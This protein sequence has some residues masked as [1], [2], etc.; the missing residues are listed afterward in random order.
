DGFQAGLRLLKSQEAIIVLLNRTGMPKDVQM[1]TISLMPSKVVPG[2]DIVVV[3]VEKKASKRYIVPTGRVIVPAGRYIVLTGSVIVVTGRTGALIFLP[4]STAEEHL[5]VQKESKAKRISGDSP[6]SFSPTTYSVTSNFKTGSHKSSNVIED[7]LYSFVAYEDLE[8]VDKLDL[9]EMDLKWQMAMLSVRVHKFE[10]KVGR[11]IDFDR[12]ESARFNMQKVRCYKCQQRGHFARECR[13]KGGN[14]KQRYSSF[15]NKEIGRKEEDSKALVFVNTLVDWSNHD[16]EC[17]EVI[18]AKEFGMIAG[19]NSRKPIL[20]VMLEN[21]LSWVSPLRTKVGLGFTD[22]ISQNE[23]GWDDS[24]FSVFTTTSEDVEG[25]PTFHRFTKT[26]SIK[27]VPPPLT[28]DYTSLSDHSDLDESQMSYG[29]NSLTSNDPKSVTNDFVSCDDSDK[30]SEVKTSDF[31]SSD[32]SGKSSEHKPTDS[33]SCTS[34]SSVST[35]VNE[36]E[37]ES[38][39]R[40]PIKEPIIV[41]DLPSFICNSSDK[42]E[43]SSRTTCNKNGSFNKRA[44]HFRKHAS[45]VSKLYFICVSGTHLIKDCDFYEKQMTNTTVGIGV[46]TAVRPQPVLLYSNPENP[47]ELFQKLLEDL[48]ELPEYEKSQSRDR[49]IFLNDDEDHF[50]Q[51]K[52]C[53]ENSS[54]EIDASSSNQEKEEPPQDSNV[55][56]LIKEC[57]MEVFEEQKQIMENTM[58]ELVKICRHK[59][60]LCIHDNVE[61]LIESALNSKLLS[62]NSQRLDNKEQEVKNVVEQPIER[63]THIEKSLKKFRVIHKSFIS[64]NTSHISSI[65]AVVPIL[66][67]KEPEYSP[68]MGY[69]NSNTTLEMES[70]EIIKSG[71]EEL[72]PILSENEVTLEDKRE[73][74][75]PV[76]ENS[77]VCD[78][79][80]EIFFDSKDDDDIS[81]YDDFKDVEY[82][83]ASLFDPEIVNQEEEN[84]VHQE[85]DE[86]DLEDISQIQD[87]DLREKLLSITR[88][89]SNIESLND[90]PTPDLVLNSFVSIPTFEESNNSLSDTFSPEFK[91]FCDHTKETR[92]GNTTHANDSLPQYDSFCFEI[93][94]DQERLINIV[95]NDISDD[96]SNDPLL[97]EADLFLAFDKSIPPGIENV[98]DDSEGDIHFLKELLIDDSILSHESSD[99]YFEDNPSVP[100]LPPEP[101]DVEF[102]AGKEIPVVINDKDE[103]VDYSSFIFVIYPKM[104]PLL[105]SAESEDTIFDPGISV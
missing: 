78:D 42:I 103:D 83:E 38:N 24:A 59:K 90:N 16:S 72:V 15:K 96:S 66:S 93:E 1:L 86:V 74:D 23:L 43:H 73:C 81:V 76:C 10:Q 35:S 2:Y 79:H 8:Q 41:Q 39:A 102:D 48:K 51:N 50:D 7:V 32:S 20:Q 100:L 5:A 49:P 84:V 57:S 97:K 47:N 91:T 94:P 36:S 3:V 104:F 58:L 12:K 30:S 89:I 77:S 55:H 62:I 98:A 14:D 19:C 95:K 46:G 54:N 34:T 4:P 63:K 88:L 105:L 40:T 52:E 65:H 27:V 44:G 92:S 6:I 101:P 29:T 18:I 87:V 70:D 22:G 53:F 26:D 82:V 25:R 9:E 31:A 56:Q 99:S 68:S 13:S 71:V 37:F 60:L 21:L 33:T 80:S 69:E 17:D 67:T 11:K 61:D 28:G 64:L 75:V 85:E 45:Y